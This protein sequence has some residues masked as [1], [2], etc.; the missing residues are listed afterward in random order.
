[1]IGQT[2]SHYRILEKLGAGG[3][4]IVYRAHDE[5]LKRDVALKVLPTE[6]TNNE[7]DRKRLHREALALSRL[8]HPNIAQIYD[9]DIQNGIAFLVMEYIRGNTLAKALTD[10]PLPE[11]EAVSVGFTDCKRVERRCGGRHHSS[12]P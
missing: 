4:G 6:T 11:E 1:M 2:I 7:D 9:F 12:G 3:M 10:G 8:S 5:R